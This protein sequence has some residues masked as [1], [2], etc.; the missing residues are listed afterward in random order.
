MIDHR[1]KKQKFNGAGKGWV[2]RG[3]TFVSVARA[4]WRL[5]LVECWN[6]A[7]SRGI[8]VQW[9]FTL[10]FQLL[11]GGALNIAA[12]RPDARIFTAAT[13]ANTEHTWTRTP[14]NRRLRKN[15]HSLSLSLSPPLPPPRVR[16]LLGIASH[17]RAGIR[18][19]KIRGTRLIVSPMAN[20]AFRHKILLAVSLAGLIHLRNIVPH[21]PS[22]KYLMSSKS[23][24]T[25]TLLRMQ[26]LNPLMTLWRLC[27]QFSIRLWFTLAIVSLFIGWYDL[28][29]QCVC[30]TRLIG[31]IRVC[32]SDFRHNWI[33]NVCNEGC[34]SLL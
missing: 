2:G 10:P 32:I 16:L 4:M 25:S 14:A 12:G 20:D 26:V 6:G 34:V 22:Y 9:R 31:R 7:H 18:A 28:S 17:L 30:V 5:L 24:P 11:I 33:A 21:F 3:K 19:I 1:T 27:T 29:S 15:D 23:V 13:L 8:P